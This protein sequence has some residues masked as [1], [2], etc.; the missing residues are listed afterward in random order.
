MFLAIRNL[1]VCIVK[2]QRREISFIMIIRK[3]HFYDLLAWIMVEE[4]L[5]LEIQ[6]TYFRK[7]R[8]ELRI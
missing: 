1:D 7:V 4:H 2:T 5:P 3:T 6:F 8:V